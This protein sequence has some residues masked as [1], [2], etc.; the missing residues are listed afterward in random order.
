MKYNNSSRPRF[1]SPMWLMFILAIV[2]FIAEMLV[3]LLLTLFRVTSSFVEAI[4]DASLLLLLVF[5]A[6]YFFFMR[7]MLMHIRNRKLVEEKLQIERDNLDERV[8]ERAKELVETNRSLEKEVAL[9]RNAEEHL[10]KFSLVAEQSPS[11]VIITDANGNIEFVNPRFEEL[12]GYSFVE[13]QGKNPRVLQSGNTSMETYKKMWE[14][15]SSN[16]SW[17]G[18]IQDKKKNGE[19]YWASASISPIT[20]S[21]GKITHYLGVQ[22]DISKRKEAELEREKLIAD[23]Q[24]A[25]DNVKTLTGLLPICAWC[26]KI[27]DEKGYWTQVEEYVMHHTEATFSHSICKECAE[28]HFKDARK[29]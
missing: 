3:M 13:V 23:L 9:R 18:E 12:T 11:S 5:P 17:K 14:T 15:I 22:V 19:T 25:L 27:R 21:E 24:T 1:Q 2:V 28:Q 7:P 26:K 20:N 8:K 16:K 4:V 6:L 29:K 10:R